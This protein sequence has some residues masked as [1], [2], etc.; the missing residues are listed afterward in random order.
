[1][2][3]TPMRSTL[4]QLSGR[5]ADRIEHGR[6]YPALVSTSRSV[7]ANLESG[8]VAVQTGPLS[9][10]P[11]VAEAERRGQERRRSQGRRLRLLLW[12]ILALVMVPTLLGHPR[13]GT[14]GAG[15]V[16]V[17][18]L[19]G[20]V[21]ATI[22]TIR[23]SRPNQELPFTFPLLPL[24][25][26]ACGIGLMATQNSVS[27]EIPATV[28]MSLAF[29]RLPLPKALGVGGV[30]TAGIVVTVVARQGGDDSAAGTLLLCVTLAL[31]ALLVRRSWEDQE[32]AERLTAEL[33]D[34]REE[35]AK[36]AALAERGRIARDLHDVLAQSLSGLAI[37]LEAARRVARRDGVDEQLSELLDRAGA[38]TRDGLTEARRAVAALRGD[39]LASLDQLPA[40]VERYRGDL[41]LDASLAISGTVRPLPAA[42]GE[43]LLRGAQEAL[44]NAARYARGSAVRVE[45]DYQ[46]S[47]T[48]LSVR[49]TRAA[50]G[51]APA[52]VITGSGLGLRGMAER[53]AQAGGRMQAGPAEDG[54][55]VRMEVPA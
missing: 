48:V 26:G 3:L 44:T 13:P 8:P 29:L 1:M 55:L 11:R 50:D 52:G 27:G 6:I 51:D 10:S 36:A 5:S 20:F 34:A 45:L 19:A 22:V 43:A 17:L 54:W 31:M 40:L 32:A 4:M 9:A 35:Y 47:M 7:P 33:H 14:S 23:M 38:L 15:L 49:D 2:R 42:A 30:I 39:A 41:R 12:P 16:V 24:L 28:A 21:I 53:L 46:E 18:C 25:M 37:Q